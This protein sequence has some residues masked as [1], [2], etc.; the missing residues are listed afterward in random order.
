[1]NNPRSLVIITSIILHTLWTVESAWV[2]G[3]TILPRADGQ[4]AAAYW[5]NSIYLFGGEG[6]VKQ[7][8]TINEQNEYHD[9]GTNVLVSSC[10]SNTQSYIQIYNTSVV[11]YIEFES[12]TNRIV[13]YDLANTN[14]IGQIF[15]DQDVDS[16]TCVTLANH[17]LYFLAGMYPDAVRRVQAYNIT[18]ETWIYSIP[19]MQTKRRN[20]GCAFDPIEQTIWAIGG[21]NLTSN[22]YWDEVTKSVEKISVD[23]ITTQLWKYSDNLII[24]TRAMSTIY[25]KGYIVV[26]GGHQGSGFDFLTDVQI[27]NCNTGHEFRADSLAYKIGYAAGILA[28]DT[29]YLFGGGGPSSDTFQYLDISLNYITSLDPIKAP[30]MNPTQVPTIAPSQLPTYSTQ[31]STVD[32]TQLPTADPTQKPAI[33]PTAAPLI[34]Y[35]RPNDV[36]SSTDD[37]YLNSTY[38]ISKNDGACIE[39]IIEFISTLLIVV[40]T[41]YNENELFVYSNI[42]QEQMN[43]FQSINNNT[44]CGDLKVFILTCFEDEI[45]DDLLNITKQPEFKDSIINKLNDSDINID[46]I[47]P[48]IVYTEKPDH[49]N[50]QLELFQLTKIYGYV[51]IVSTSICALAEI[52]GL[53]DSKLFRINDYFKMTAIISI[54]LQSNDMISDF[55]FCIQMYIISKYEMSL[56]YYM[57]LALSAVFIII[58]TC[59]S[60]TQ[61]FIYT[62]THFLERND[63]TAWLKKYTVCLLILS[64]FIGN[65]FSAVLMA[66]SYLFQSNV[67]GMGLTNNELK[68]FK[69]KRVYSIVLFENVPQVVIQSYYIWISDPKNDFIAVASIVFSAIS[70]VVSIL[71]AILEKQINF[72]ESRVVISMDIVGECIMQNRGKCKWMKKK[73]HSELAALVRTNKSSLEIVKPMSISEGLRLKFY[74]YCTD[75]DKLQNMD[76]KGIVVNSKHKGKLALLIH[77]AW[78]LLDDPHIK[79]IDVTYIQ[80]KQKRRNS[81]QDVQMV[82]TANNKNKKNALSEDGKGRKA[83]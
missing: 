13:I 70:I 76:Y 1:M 31:L 34:R 66:N 44:F 21:W 61:L 58:P 56:K 27:I 16:G 68:R 9:K 36:C 25:Y 6:N 53:L 26:M 5:N 45:E 42:S 77:R 48:T 29:M 71:S 59:L 67:F 22:P 38:E 30:T 20:H 47:D 51:F 79:N 3:G 74:I 41:V 83:M 62:K 11:Y 69:A 78:G 72:T 65:P 2:N 46:I 4:M 55:I 82:R 73:L 10:R 15:T 12:G 39:G 52:L 28:Y 37:G 57:L 23:A 40:E 43:T 60:L 17:V 14:E 32:T 33:D 64:V 49:D 63:V 75:N 24:E 50:M 8:L 7:L 35:I 80:S 19:S 18:S 54:F 81:D